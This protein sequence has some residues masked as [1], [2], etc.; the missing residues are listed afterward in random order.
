MRK[1][2]EETFIK[3]LKDNGLNPS[4]TLFIDDTSE[5]IQT[6]T[7]LGL[8]TYEVKNDE[9]IVLSLEGLV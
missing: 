9:E 6:A 3:V 1:P 7:Q 8:H 5:N 4:E 2:N